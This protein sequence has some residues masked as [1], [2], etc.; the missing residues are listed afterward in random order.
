MEQWDDNTVVATI[1]LVFYVCLSE[2]SVYEEDVFKT[3][4]PA[5][6]IYVYTRVGK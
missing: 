4:K 3:I 6:G 1:S 2:C 5:W